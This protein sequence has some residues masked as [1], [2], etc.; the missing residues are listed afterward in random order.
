[1]RIMELN[2][3]PVDQTLR[4]YAKNPSLAMNDL[5]GNYKFH[6][7]GSST[8]S[9]FGAYGSMT[10]STAG[11]TTFPDYRDSTTGTSLSADS[12]TLSY[13]PDAGSKSYPDFANFASQAQDGALHYYNVSTPLHTYFDFWS[14]PS[15]ITSPSTWRELLLSSSYYNEHGSLSY[16]GDLFV[17]TRSEPA[18]NCLVIGL[19]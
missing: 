10:I 12:F 11:V 9:A 6:K 5:A 14:Y 17:L 15:V 18:G 7:I 19:K 8:V 13:L 1:M 4:D 3:L 16:N 2:F